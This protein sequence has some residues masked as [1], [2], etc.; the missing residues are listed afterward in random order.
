[1]LQG[2]ASTAVEGLG[3]A[4]KV[5]GG[6]E[7]GPSSVELARGVGE[8]AVDLG[9]F[10][11]NAGKLLLD[12]GLGPAWFTDEVE[13]LLFLG[14]QCAQAGGEASLEAVELELAGDLRDV[15]TPVPLVHLPVSLAGPKPF[16][17]TGP[18]RRCRGRFPPFPAIPG[19]GCPQLRHAAATAQR[20]RSFTSARKHSASWRT[21]SPSQWPAT[22]RSSTSVGRRSRVTSGVIKPR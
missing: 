22:A 12:L 17:S 8:L 10:Q 18:S 7:E 14:V 19:S 11:L 16:G 20:R 5:E 3:V 2:S 6:E 13:V 1:M 15:T 9:S 21:R 4:E